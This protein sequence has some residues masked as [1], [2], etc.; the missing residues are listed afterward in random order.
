[1]FCNSSKVTIA[2]R[3]YV[4]TERIACLLIDGSMIS[5]ICLGDNSLLLEMIGWL[6]SMVLA[7]NWDELAGE[8]IWED[9]DY[10]DAWESLII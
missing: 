5:K 4:D 8:E 6:L 3:L 9:V 2:I 7:V 1:M 10:V